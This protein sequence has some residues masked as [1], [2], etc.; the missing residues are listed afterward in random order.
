M[1]GLK[2]HAAR[3]LAPYRSRMGVVQSGK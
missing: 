3:E 2:E 1:V